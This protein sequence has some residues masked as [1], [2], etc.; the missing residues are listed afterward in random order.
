MDNGEIKRS[1][2]GGTMKSKYSRSQLEHF[3]EEWVLGLNA[4]RNKQIIKDKFFEGMT[5]QKIAEKHDLSETRVKTVIRTFKH[6]I[7]AH[8]T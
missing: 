4:A 5:I 7:D 8:V 6:K 1:P 2:H 3:I